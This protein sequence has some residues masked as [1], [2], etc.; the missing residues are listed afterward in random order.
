MLNSILFH[1]KKLIPQVVFRGLQPAYHWCMALAAAIFYR[2]PSRQIKIVAVTGTKGKTS[3]TE[4]TNAILEQAGFKTALCNTIRFKVGDSS[5]DNLYKMSMPGRFFIQKFLRQAVKAG[6]DYVVMEA[7]SQGALMQRHKFI[8][9]DALIFTNIAPEHIEAH[10]S[11]ENYVNAKVSI[12]R[13]V[14]ASKKSRRIIVANA[15]DAQAQ[16][17]LNGGF[18]RDFTDK[19]PYSLDDAKPFNL[20]KEGFA[21]TVQGVLI[22][23]QLSGE[24]NIYNELAA[25]TFALSQN[26]PIETCRL[27]IEKHSVIRGRVER[28]EAGQDFAVVVDYAHTPDSLQQFYRVFKGSRRICILGNTG[29]GRDT[30]KRDEMARIAESECDEIILTN[31]D[32]YDDDPQAIVDDM[33]RAL[34]IKTP[35]VIMDRREAIAAAINMARTGDS[36]LITGKGT[37]PFIMGPNNTKIPWSDAAVAREELEKLANRAT[38]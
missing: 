14:A 6:C 34:T 19:L 25:I 2:F 27:A 10:G 23:S 3:V 9:F 16:K 29:G 37:D 35:H 21:M 5:R 7:T 26:I 17:F 36:V 8:Q 11:F 32:P 24:F 18:K 38:I 12:A 15:D 22:K 13:A 31:E 1:I 30:W 4:M 28:I 33:A 20:F